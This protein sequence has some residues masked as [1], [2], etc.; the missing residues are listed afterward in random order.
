MISDLGYRR[1]LRPLLFRAYGGD[2]ERIHEQTW[3]QSLGSG[4]AD[5]HSPPWPPSAP[6]TGRRPPSPAS[7]S[8]AWSGSPLGWTRTGWASRPGVPSALATSS[9]AQS[10]RSRSQAMTGPDCSDCPTAER[11]STG[12]ASTISVRH[13]LAERL[14]AAGVSRGNLAVGIPIGISIGKTKKVPLDEAA[15]DYLASLRTVARYADYLAINVSSPNTPGTAFA[16]GCR[17][18]GGPASQ[19]WSTEAWRLAAGAPPGADLRQ[20]GARPHRGSAGGGRA[21]LYRSRCRGSH[22]HQHDAW[23]ATA[24]QQTSR[25]PPKPAACREHRSPDA[26]GTWCAS[27]LTAPHCRSLASA[28]S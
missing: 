12:W 5:R 14:A 9:W 24:S 19:R 1:I 16:A 10:P 4:G 7:R 17:D 3:R 23:P 11:S 2:A 8:R 6:D 13:A 22:R 15:E 28:A 26:P 27:W 21:G 20:G 18:P 25:W